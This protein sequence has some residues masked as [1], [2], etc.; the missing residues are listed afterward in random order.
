MTT[1]QII[2]NRAVV[3]QALEA[4]DAGVKISPNSVLH[5]R[6]RAALKQPVEQSAEHGEPVAWWNPAK[7]T[8]STDPVHRHNSDCFPLYAQ[9]QEDT[10]LL[11]QALEAMDDMATDSRLL[12]MSATRI[13]IF[14]T[15]RDALR[16]RLK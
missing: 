12:D 11:R 7:D 14:E 13:H 2:I 3:E 10:S 16:E 4:L 9:A 1:N 5:D 15:A 6:L 8:V